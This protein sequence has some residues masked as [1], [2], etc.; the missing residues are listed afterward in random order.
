MGAG[1]QRWTDR[2]MESI[3]GRLL[4]IGVIASAA[5][6][7]AGGILYLARYGRSPAE[8]SVFRGEPPFLHGLGGMIKGIAAADG[9]AVIQLGLILLILTPVAR[10][11]FSATAFMLKRDLLYAA[12]SLFVLSVL[13]HN[14]LF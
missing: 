9:R 3:I 12:V 1:R 7:I 4:R 2:R 10:V 14:L 8:Y 13:L 5:V 11:A 6:V